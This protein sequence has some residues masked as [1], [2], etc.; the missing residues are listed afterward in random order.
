MLACPRF[1]LLVSE[2]SLKL[3]D[4]GV[5]SPSVCVGDLNGFPNFLTYI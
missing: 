2:T 3:A 4:T 5:D 1:T